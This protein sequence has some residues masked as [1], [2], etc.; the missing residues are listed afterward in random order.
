M[1]VEHLLFA[2]EGKWSLTWHKAFAK[3]FN[4]SLTKNLKLNK[5]Y[6]KVNKVKIKPSAENKGPLF[7]KLKGFAD[8]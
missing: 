4:K 6:E 3:C 1:T 5:H 2:G 7:Y 8:I